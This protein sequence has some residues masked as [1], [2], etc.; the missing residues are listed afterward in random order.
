M[1]EEG[2]G[3]D[4]VSPPPSAPAESKPA[5]TGTASAGGVKPPAEAAPASPPAV[6][7]P[8]EEKPAEPKPAVP[9][10]AAA[11]KPAEVKP[12]APAADKPAAAAAKPAAPAATP[13]APAAKPAAPATEKP[14]A[15][16]PRETGRTGRCQACRP[17]ETGWSGARAVGLRADPFAQ[18]AVRLGH[19]GSQHLRWAEIS[20]GRQHDRA[21]HPS[22]H[23]R[24]RALRLLRRHH[25][26]ALS[27]ARAAIRCDLHPLF[28]PP[29][30]SHP[31]EDPDRRR[32][33]R[34]LRGRCLAHGQL[35]GARG[36]STCSA[37][38][39]TGIPT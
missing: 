6:V 16:C 39:S 21:R 37:S 5:P 3:P 28:V 27:Q 18:A 13:A 4:P 11:A 33:A 32:P 26:R 29:Q 23:A 17:G 2:K 24:R 25:R 19:Q 31:G 10:A 22:A 34:Y 20:G 36:L 30:R 7:R 15:R 14:A 8:G 12:A 9:A 35:A 1:P 38:S